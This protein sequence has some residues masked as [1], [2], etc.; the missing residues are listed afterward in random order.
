MRQWSASWD[1]TPRPARSE[2]DPSGASLFVWGVWILM[3]LAALLFV[4]R[5]GANLPMWDEWAIIPAVTGGKPI[6]AQFLWE[7]HNEHR[8]PLPKI[9][10]VLL[11]R[12]TRCDY[13]A[14]MYLNVFVLGAVAS[15]MVRA[16]K[17]LRGSTSYTDALF[18][19]ALSASG[20]SPK[21]LVRLPGRLRRVSVPYEHLASHHP[22]SSFR[23][24]PAK[25]SPGRNM[26]QLVAALWRPG[27][28][29]RATLGTLVW[30][31]RAP[32]MGLR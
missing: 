23:V 27:S 4:V 15:A 19:L 1:L 22:R 26:P 2:V 29:P 12:L 8:I 28:D 30:L 31:C 7:Q 32:P 20:A 16:A 6:T 21:F 14:G 24:K 11:S 3:M 13:R 25:L 5:Y 17:S 9:I 18:P 10:L